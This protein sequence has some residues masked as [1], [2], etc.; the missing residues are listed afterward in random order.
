[1]GDLCSCSLTGRCGKKSGAFARGHLP[2]AALFGSV[3]ISAADSDVSTSSTKA[4][5]KPQRTVSLMMADTVITVNSRVVCASVD[6]PYPVKQY[7]G[8]R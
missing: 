8:L 3:S 1:M 5:A 4:N 6:M 2:A 7:T